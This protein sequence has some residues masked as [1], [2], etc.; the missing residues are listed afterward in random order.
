MLH[1]YSSSGISCN[2]RIFLFLN[3]ISFPAAHTKKSVLCLGVGHDGVRCGR[4]VQNRALQLG[5]DTLI[6]F[7]IVIGKVEWSNDNDN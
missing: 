6:Q 7:I 5:L 2:G 1:V 4:L 3:P